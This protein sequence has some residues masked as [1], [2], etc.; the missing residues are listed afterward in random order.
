MKTGKEARITG[1]ET[2]FKTYH[3][4]LIFSFPTCLDPALPGFRK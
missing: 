3:P 1:K 4:M 2:L